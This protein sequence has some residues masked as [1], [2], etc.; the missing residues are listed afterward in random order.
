LG[1]LLT[2]RSLLTY[3][4]GQ[5]EWAQEMLER[6]LKILRP[7]DDARVLVEPITFLGTVM[8]LTGDYARAAELFSEGREKAI[9]VGDR[10][11]AAMCISLQGSI[12]MYFGQ[13]E[14]AHERLLTAVA[15]WRA[16]GD[17][18][19]TAFGLNHL[20]QSALT[21]ERFD[22]ARAALEESVA[23]N[24]S[25]GAHWNLGHAYEGLGA[26]ARAQ[27]EHHRAVEMFGKCVDAFTELGGRFYAAQGLAEMGISLFMLGNDIEAERV[28]REA[29]RIAIEIHGIPVALNALI[30]LA[31]LLAKRGEV[32][33]ALELLLIVMNHPAS[34][35]ETRDRASHLRAELE[36]QLTPLQIESIKDHA[37]EITL[38]SVV[39]GLL[40]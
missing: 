28:W 12:A 29:L 16:I 17:P 38:E 7:L 10:W 31:S 33:Q 32:K 34:I 30:G 23:L 5:H 1:H 25:V 3:R 14:V 8:T 6:G 15:E 35:Q 19:F 11:F 26:V 40:R 4:L 39:E 22:E 24:M 18:R 9:A 2:T 36:T 20:G 13:H 37:G 21:L 27:G